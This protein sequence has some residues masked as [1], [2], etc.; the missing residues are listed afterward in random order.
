MIYKV[1]PEFQH[2]VLGDFN[3]TQKLTIG[4]YFDEIDS[5]FINAHKKRTQQ[6]D[7]IYSVELVLDCEVKNEFNSFLDV[8][9]TSSFNC[10]IKKDDIVK[11]NAN[12][13]SSISY[14]Y[15]QNKVIVSFEIVENFEF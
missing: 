9:S 11:I 7:N 4:K 2:D 14:S 15:S 8:I 12:I 10:R 6:K 3:R 13:V 1:F 5:S